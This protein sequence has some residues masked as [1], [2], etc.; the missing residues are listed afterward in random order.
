MTYSLML[1]EMIPDA[2]GVSEQV[3]N[4]FYFA[5]MAFLLCVFFMTVLRAAEQL[6]LRGW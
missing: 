3:V 5:L 4:I 6:A 1:I 2:F